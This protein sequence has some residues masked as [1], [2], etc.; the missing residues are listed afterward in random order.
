MAIVLCAKYYKKVL[1]MFNIF[2][3]LITL[4]KGGTLLMKIKVKSV[5][6]TLK[7]VVGYDGKKWFIARWI[8]GD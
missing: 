6:D 4:S 5:S 7:G 1:T 2:D 3:K 8:K